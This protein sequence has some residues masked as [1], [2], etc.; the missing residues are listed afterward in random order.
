MRLAAAAAI[1]GLTLVGT[2]VVPAQAD[3]ASIKVTGIKLKPIVTYNAGQNFIGG[4]IGLDWDE[5]VDIYDVEAD[6][7][8]NGKTVATSVPLAPNGFNY[9]RSWGAGTVQLTN[10][11]VTGTDANTGDFTDLPVAT[12]ANSVQ[13]RHAVDPNSIIKYKRVGKKLTF[14][15]T[16]RYIS[17]TGKLISVG[18]AT[19]QYKKAGKWKKLKTLKLNSAGFAKY[20]IYL[21]KKRS[22]RLVV[23]GTNVFQSASTGP[24]KK[25]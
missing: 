20:K 25:I 4:T 19:I 17:A 16:V 15:A 10:V 22:Y 2:A 12:P 1:A 8:V 9:N 24:S 21:K 11:K 6:V 18:K 13:V 7:K 14:K 3:T 5:D 23:V